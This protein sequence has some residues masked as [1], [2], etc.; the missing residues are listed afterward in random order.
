MK[1]FETYVIMLSQTFPAKHPKAGQPT[2]FAEKVQEALNYVKYH[3]IEGM[4]PT[5]RAK[6][7]TMRTNWELWSLSSFVSR[8]KPTATVPLSLFSPTHAAMSFVGVSSRL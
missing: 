2:E 8:A 1:K 4:K 5:P 6:I 3:G 7:H